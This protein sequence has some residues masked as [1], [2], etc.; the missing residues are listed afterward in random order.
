MS[1]DWTQEVKQFKKEYTEE[2]YHIIEDGISEYI[3]GI[4]PIYYGDIY[5]TYH[6]VIGT[7]LNIEIKP[8]HVGMPFWHIMNHQIYEEFYSLFMEAWNEAEE[9]E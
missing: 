2:D 1:I 9:E 7:P 3:D 8:E 6:D 5:Q 4:L